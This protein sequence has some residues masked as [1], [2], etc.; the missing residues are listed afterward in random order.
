MTAAEE[1][2]S[3]LAYEDAATHSSSPSTGRSVWYVRSR[4]VTR[5]WQG[6]KE[7]QHGVRS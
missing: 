1:E 7:S 3:V 4:A 2:D 5:R 6:T